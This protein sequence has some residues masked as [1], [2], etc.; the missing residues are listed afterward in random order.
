MTRSNRSGRPARERRHQRAQRD[1][2]GAGRRQCDGRAKARL[3]VRPWLTRRIVPA[4]RHRTRLVARRHLRVAGKHPVRGV[5]AVDA[6]DRPEDRL[7]VSVGELE[8]EPELR[9]RSFDVCDVQ[10]RMF[11]W[12]SASTAA[13]S[14]SRRERSSASTSTDT[15]NVAGWSW[16]HSTSMTRSAWFTSPAAFAQSCGAPTP[17]V[18]A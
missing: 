16:S 1:D 12:Y 17:R 15:T 18:R 9:H 4:T 8:V 13:T 7:E 11:T 5:H 10:A 14:R 2:S 6:L 3:V